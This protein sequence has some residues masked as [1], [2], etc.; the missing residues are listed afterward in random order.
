MSENK[1]E[2]KISDDDSDVAYLKLHD[3]LGSGTPGVVAKQISLGEI[4]KDYKG[5]DVHLV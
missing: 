3:H 5:A 2:L 1:F 4:I